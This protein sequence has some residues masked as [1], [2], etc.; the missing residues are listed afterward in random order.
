MFGWTTEFT[1]I[2]SSPR[3]AGFSPAGWE[4][5]EGGTPAL[6][7]QNDSWEY[8]CDCLLA[9][10]RLWL[11]HFFFLDVRRACRLV[12][13]RGCPAFLPPSRHRFRLASLPSGDRVGLG[14]QIIPFRPANAG[15][16]AAWSSPVP[17]WPCRPAA[18]CSI[19]RDSHSPWRYRHRRSGHWRIPD[20]PC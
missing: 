8:S 5:M 13:F 10:N 19:A 6:L 14:I 2:E 1:A 16:I 18:G 17:A 9:V 12:A 20:S 3:S 15:S 7:R 11:L 4:C